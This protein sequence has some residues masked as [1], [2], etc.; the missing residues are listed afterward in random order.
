MKASESGPLL[1]LISASL[2]ATRASASS[3]LASRNLPPSRISGLVNRS[4]L[5]TKSQPNFPL[6]QVEMPLVGPS[7]GS[8]F[9]I[10]RSLVQTSKL[11]PT[12]QYVQTVLVRRIRDSRI[13]DSASETFMI[14]P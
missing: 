3:Q 7:L 8:T 9:R 5:F 4:E 12:P 14:A 11:Q 10:W 2:R 6:M 13:T 1:A